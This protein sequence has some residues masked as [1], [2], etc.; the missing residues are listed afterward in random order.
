MPEETTNPT[1]VALKCIV[2]MMENTLI[3]EDELV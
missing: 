1:N 2:K 3:C